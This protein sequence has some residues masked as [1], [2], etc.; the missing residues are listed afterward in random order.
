MMKKSYN[1]GIMFRREYPP[2][3]LTSF[4]IKTELLGFSELWVVEDCFYASGIAPAAAALTSTDS[5]TVGLGIMPAVARNPVFTAMEIATLA[6][7]FPGRFLPGIGHG[8]AEWMRQIGAFPKSQLRA[9]EEVTEA[10]RR[11]LAGD[12]ISMDGGHVQLDRAKLVYPPEQA[13]PVS[14]GVIGPKSLAVSGRV[15]DGTILSEYSS[16]AYVTWALDHIARGRQESELEHGQRITLFAFACPAP[17]TDAARERIRPMLADA[18]ASGGIDTKL[19]SM[20]VLP[21]VQAYLEKESSANLAAWIPDAW[22]D[23]LTI[24]GT[25]RDWCEAIDRFIKC[26]VHSVV[27]VPLPD[28]NPDEVE[29]FA[30]HLHL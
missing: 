17:T 30:Q 3:T 5:L 2:E 9:L 20:G 23:Q 4:A 8:V 16:P 14:L 1:L 7:I 24:A 19:A 29:A 25:P 6:R 15:A 12:E 10:V 13:P 11:F 27:L 28:T 26:G 18:I 21:E 22:I